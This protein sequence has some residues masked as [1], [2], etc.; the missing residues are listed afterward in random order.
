MI[1]I[2]VLVRWPNH[3]GAAVSP[4]REKKLEHRAEQHSSSPSCSTP[5]QS[6]LSCF[7]LLDRSSEDPVGLTAPEPTE[8]RCES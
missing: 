1:I 7:N 8:R 3:G 4:A 6:R 2:R 5:L